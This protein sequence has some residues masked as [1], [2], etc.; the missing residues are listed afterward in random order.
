[1]TDDGLTCGQAAAILR[2]AAP[3]AEVVGVQRMAG[4]AMTGAYE[5]LCADPAQNV[6]VK[7]Y[8][9]NNGWTLSKEVSVYRLLRENGVTK[10]PKILGGAG[11]DGVL[12][13]PYLVMSR[14]PG[15]PAE[16]LSSSLSEADLRSLY[17]QMGELIA[18]FHAIEQ[19]AYGFRDTGILDPR[20]TNEAQTKATLARVSQYY[21]DETGDRDLYEAA[22]KYVAARTDLFALCRAPVLIHNDF[23][24]GNVIVE[25]TPGGP[26]V[27]GVIDVENAMAGDPMVDL[28][29][30]HSYSIGEN[31]VKL[32]ALFEGYGEV[33]VEWEARFP[34][35]QL[36]H[37][38]E[39][40][41]HFHD[42][43]RRKWADTLVEDMRRIIAA[44]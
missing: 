11:C 4:G 43:G 6:V 12:G 2:E 3:N 8:P 32:E 26:V 27:S 28:S 29:K 9:P 39:L 10:I 20:P 42:I 7:I 41:C 14:L 21:L 23:H 38:F 44:G 24:E 15:V 37:S 16:P 35:F 17:R 19:E 36:V 33:P 25:Q 5:V 34:L 30:T 31:S 40:W 18:Q 1:V 13:S 22:H